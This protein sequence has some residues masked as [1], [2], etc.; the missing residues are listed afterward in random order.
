MTTNIA[1][2]SIAGIT[3]IVGTIVAVSMNY[4]SKAQFTEFK[5]GTVAQI[6]KRMDKMDEKL[7]LI[8]LEQRRLSRNGER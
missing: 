2:G 7:D 4:V 5:D 8:I 1:I 3:T 6:E